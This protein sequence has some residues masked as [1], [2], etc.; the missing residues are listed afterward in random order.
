[1]NKETITFI[2]HTKEKSSDSS[3]LS[4]EEIDELVNTFGFIT[5]FLEVTN[6]K[7]VTLISKHLKHFF[8]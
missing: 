8:R 3:Y 7:K 5:S 6:C 1:M 4:D 2:H